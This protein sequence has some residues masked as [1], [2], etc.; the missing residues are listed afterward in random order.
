M[1]IGG[2]VFRGMGGVVRKSRLFNDINGRNPT[3]GR[4][5]RHGCDKNCDKLPV[6]RMKHG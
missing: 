5:P 6:I 1:Q 2:A 3:S 4:V